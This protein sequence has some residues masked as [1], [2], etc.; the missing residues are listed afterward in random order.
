MQT[1]DRVAGS[2]QARCMEVACIATC[3]AHVEAP[4]ILMVKCI[5]IY[6]AVQALPNEISQRTEP[7]LLLHF[8]LLALQEG[9]CLQG[10]RYVVSRCHA[11]LSAT[12][13]SMQTPPHVSDRFEL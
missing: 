1:T 11:L 2:K 8:S 6:T 3:Q 5:Y 12:P 13:R 7:P 9:L 4:C 10:Y